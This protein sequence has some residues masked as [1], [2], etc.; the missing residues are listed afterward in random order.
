MS[1]L[2]RIPIQKMSTLV[3]SLRRLSTQTRLIV[4]SIIL[5]FDFAN[6]SG[7]LPINVPEQSIDESRL[8]ID[9]GLDESVWAGLPRLGDLVVVAPDTFEKTRFNTQPR[10]FNMTEGLY[11]GADGAQPVASL[12]PRLSSRDANVSRDSVNFFLDPSGKGF[13]GYYFGVNLGGTLSDGTLFPE[14][15]FSPLWDGPWRRAT[16]PTDTGIGEALKSILTD[17]QFCATIEIK[18]MYLNSVGHNDLVCHSE[19]IKR[20]RRGAVLKSEVLSGDELI[21]K[22][23]GSFAIKGESHG[24]S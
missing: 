3:R 7:S 10:M 23:S 19:V 16:S 24:A 20:G 15:Q 22:A 4:V 12:L 9:G 6:A 17:D 8:M 11:I 14:H 21:A 2:D 1:I 13:Y 5:V 18:I